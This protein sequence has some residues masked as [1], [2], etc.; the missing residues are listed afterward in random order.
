MKKEVKAYRRLQKQLN[1][2][3]VGFPATFT[4]ADIRL[5]KTIFTPGQAAVAAYLNFKNLSLRDVQEKLEG[6]ELSSRDVQEHLD[7]MARNGAIALGDSRMVPDIEAVNRPGLAPRDGH[8]ACAPF[9]TCFAP[10]TVLS[11]RLQ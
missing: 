7:A 1:S 9:S 2:Q 10:R 5:L 6:S 3:A 8:L 11:S 4:G